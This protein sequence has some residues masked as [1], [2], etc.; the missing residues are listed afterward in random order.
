ML[1]HAFEKWMRET[2]YQEQS[3]AWIGSKTGSGL[4]AFAFH[5]LSVTPFFSCSRTCSSRIISR[6][7]AWMPVQPCRD[8]HRID[9]LKLPLFW[10]LQCAGAYFGILP[11]VETLLCTYP[12]PISSTRPGQSHLIQHRIVFDSRGPFPSCFHSFRTGVTLGKTTVCDQGP[13][14]SRLGMWL[15]DS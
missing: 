10:L 4:L 13:V 1:T 15:A 14:P 9:K 11:L 8:L 5:R 3:L 7:L 2:M 12:Q 6:R